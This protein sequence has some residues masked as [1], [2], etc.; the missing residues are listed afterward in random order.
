MGTR[1]DVADE[2]WEPPRIPKKRPIDVV[3][4]AAVALDAKERGLVIDDTA[5][6]ETE[7]VDA[8]DEM[9]ESTPVTASTA[10]E[11]ELD[12]CGVCADGGNGGLGDI[13]MDDAVETEAT[14]AAEGAASVPL[15][16]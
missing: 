8:E 6:D 4:E 12:G 7:V 5:V 16:K 2:R 9:G 14:V 1:G 10:A 11:K 15:W 3:I 13:N